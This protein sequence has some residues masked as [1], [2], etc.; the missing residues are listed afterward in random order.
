MGIT[1]GQDNRLYVCVL[2]TDQVKVMDAGE[3]IIATYNVGDGP[4]SIAL[5]P[6]I[7]SVPPEANITP[8]RFYLRQNYPNPFNGVTNIPYQLPVGVSKSQLEIANVIGQT[9]RL[10]PIAGN[11]IAVW[12][13]RNQNGNAVSAGIYWVR[14]S[15]VGSNMIIKTVYLP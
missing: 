9:I 1:S 2:E 7:E 13:G 3:S 10:L 14:M 8:V 5:S 4:Q 6:P 11:G 15:G 12:D